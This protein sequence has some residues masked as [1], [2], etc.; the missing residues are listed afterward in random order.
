MRELN[1]AASTVLVE[2]RVRGATDVTGFGLLGHGLEMARAS[3]TRFAFEAAALAGL[4]LPGAIDLIRAG[5]ETTGAGHNRRFVEPSLSVGPNVASEAIALALDP[6]TSGGL[7]AAV[8][9]RVVD[10]VIR[11]LAGIGVEASILGRVES[12]LEPGVGVT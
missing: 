7:L 5:V 3:G 1:G 11:D 2:H 10:S 4:A 8:P 6:Q 9:P 12:S